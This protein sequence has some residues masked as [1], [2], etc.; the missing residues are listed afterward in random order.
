MHRSDWAWLQTLNGISG[1]WSHSFILSSWKGTSP[2]QTKMH[3]YPC[4]MS[5]TFNTRIII[6]LGIVYC[7]RNAGSK[8]DCGYSHSL[9]LPPPWAT[10]SKAHCMLIMSQ[11]LLSLLSYNSACVALYL[12]LSL[13]TPFQR[14]EIKA[15]QPVWRKNK[16]LKH[17]FVEIVART[18]VLC[19]WF[20]RG[21]G[22]GPPS[23]GKRA[24]IPEDNKSE[25]SLQKR[26]QSSTC[27]GFHRG[28]FYFA[29]FDFL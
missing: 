28:G 24:N 16:Y 21:P 9:H 25:M 20:L 2:F 26:W 3:L 11:K 19:V 12:C 8:R 29:A 7:K 22:Y 18:T 14:K 4:K 1:I 10:S 6:P 5:G 15:E 27:G 17:L 13:I 23:T